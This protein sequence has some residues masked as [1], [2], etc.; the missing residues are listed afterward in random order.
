[1]NKHILIA[2][3]ELDV[4]ETAKLRLQAFGYKVTTTMGEKTIE[5]VRK[6]KP[7]LILLDVIMPGMDGF[8]VIRELKRDP[9]LAKIPVVVFSAKPRAAMIELFSP[10]GIAGY[11]SKPYDAKEL[12]KQINQILGV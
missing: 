7:D 2:D 4:I 8:A 6:A 1:M 3:D 10:E 12:L 11:I 9:E 5:D